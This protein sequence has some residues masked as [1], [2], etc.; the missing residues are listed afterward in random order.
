MNIELPELAENGFDEEL[1]RHMLK[2]HTLTI[3]G[4]NVGE[5][6]YYATSSLEHET[7]YPTEIVAL[8]YNKKAAAICFLAL[9][10]QVDRS[11]GFMANGDS[12]IPT[13]K[14]LWTFRELND[15]DNIVL[16]LCI[17]VILASL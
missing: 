16:T 11:V 10:E 1:L 2:Q 4:N 15:E 17:N 3:K 6:L 9:V 5:Y 14:S 7:T 8:E 13:R 12:P